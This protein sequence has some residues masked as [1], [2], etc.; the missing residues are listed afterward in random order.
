MKKLITLS[1]AVLFFTVAFAQYD[2]GNRKNDDGYNSKD[3]VYNDN[4]YNHDDRRDDRYT[5]NNREKEMQIA[6]INREYDR[7]IASVK[8]NWFMSRSKKN[9]VICSLEEQRNDEI[10]MVFARYNH[11]NNRFDDH[12][13]WK[14]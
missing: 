14:H 1:A 9:A 10:R 7:R 4:R 5:F 2:K 6:R 8:H 11:R 12:D 3:V 13:S